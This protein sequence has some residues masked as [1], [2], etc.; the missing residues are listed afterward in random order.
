MFAKPHNH[1]QYGVPRTRAVDV[2]ATVKTT[3]ACP[4]QR[5]EVDDTGFVSDVS[6]LVTPGRRSH[7]KATTVHIDEQRPLFPIVAVFPAGEEVHRH[8]IC[9]NN[10]SIS[11]GKSDIRSTLGWGR[12]SDA[13]HH[14]S[15]HYGPGL[16]R[17]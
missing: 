13:P 11:L 10:I 9:R 15:L 6:V 3:W 4:N 8:L 1:C 5:V 17:M 16:R 12:S 14:D 2:T 7:N